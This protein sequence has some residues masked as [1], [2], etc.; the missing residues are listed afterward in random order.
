MR[1]FGQALRLPPPRRMAA[2]GET[3]AGWNRIV[4]EQ[5]LQAN[6]GCNLAVLRGNEYSVTE[7]PDMTVFTVRSPLPTQYGQSLVAQD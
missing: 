6:E 3:G 5:V 4:V 1:R 2:T 7:K